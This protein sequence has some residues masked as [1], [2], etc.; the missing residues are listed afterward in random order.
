L[1]IEISGK[2]S[3]DLD[4]YFCWCAEQGSVT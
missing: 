3:H 2:I 1:D 4:S